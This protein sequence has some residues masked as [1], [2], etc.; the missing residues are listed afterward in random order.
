MLGASATSPVHVDDASSVGIAVTSSSDEALGLSEWPPLPHT[1]DVGMID[2]RSTDWLDYSHPPELS[3]I[4]VGTPEDVIWVVKESLVKDRYRAPS[5][6]SE[7]KSPS[8]R[9]SF[10]PDSSPPIPLEPQGSNSSTRRHYS[11]STSSQISSTTTQSEGSNG[12]TK[13][14]PGYTVKMGPLGWIIVPDKSED[15]PKKSKSMR[16]SGLK[17]FLKDRSRSV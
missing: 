9:S 17:K 1:A 4:P 2:D 6:S 7:R 16:E 11:V 13:S 12:S 5:I 10:A 14:I 15:A 3:D 8:W